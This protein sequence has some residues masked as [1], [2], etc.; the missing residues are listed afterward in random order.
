MK[1]HSA[2]DLT[3]SKKIWNGSVSQKMGMEGVFRTREICFVRL[4]V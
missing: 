3:E 2:Q 1:E 4:R